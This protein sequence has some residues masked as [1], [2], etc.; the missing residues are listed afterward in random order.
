MWWPK[1]DYITVYVDDR[2]VRLRQ[3]QYIFIDIEL[4]SMRC[5]SSIDLSI[6]SCKF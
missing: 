4:Q 3:D 2:F 1:G 6:Y 5:E